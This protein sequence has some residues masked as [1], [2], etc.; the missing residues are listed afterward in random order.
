MQ[1]VPPSSS[2]AP[3]P[4]QARGIGRHHVEHREGYVL[5]RAATKP[6]A[7]GRRSQPR[8]ISMGNI[9]DIYGEIWEIYGSGLILLGKPTKLQDFTPNIGAS[10]K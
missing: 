8:A 9:W 1:Q 3:I 7:W 6:W 4:H 10:C 2:E 5:P